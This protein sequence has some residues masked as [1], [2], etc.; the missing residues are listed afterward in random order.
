MLNIMAQATI[1]AAASRGGGMPPMPKEA[2]EPGSEPGFATVLSRLGRRTAAGNAAAGTDDHSPDRNRPVAGSIAAPVANAGTTARAGAEQ[3]H[4]MGDQ[5]ATGE[6]EGDAARDVRDPPATASAVPANGRSTGTIPATGKAS[7]S[8][9]DTDTDTNTERSPDADGSGTI[10][11]TP[12]VHPEQHP[13][14]AIRD[15]GDVRSARETAREA[16]PGSVGPMTA[17]RGSAVA[18][19]DGEATGTGEA[20]SGPTAP[21]AASATPKRDGATARSGGTASAAAGDG[22][23]NTIPMPQPASTSMAIGMVTPETAKGFRPATVPDR[24]VKGSPTD[25]VMPAM[26]EMVRRTD[27]SGRIDLSLHPTDLGSVR[28]EIAHGADGRMSVV[29]T[30]SDATTLHG[31]I[32]DQAHLHAA[33]ETAMPTTTEHRVS[34]VLDAGRGGE[35]PGTANQ[36]AGGGGNEGRGGGG[37]ERETAGGRRWGGGNDDR[38]AAVAA[39]PVAVRTAHRVLV[40]ITA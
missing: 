29:V 19:A 26:V 39:P 14:D 3:E 36:P 21:G 35:Q 23:E 8:L 4:G 9:Q 22:G 16:G 11:P 40:N 12:F 25:Q 27:G 15:H 17:D 18:D 7:V 34:F 38:V 10:M 2:T 32:A 13:A 24:P 28:V 20:H 5:A 30:A 37:R 6:M 1:G 33:L 31:L